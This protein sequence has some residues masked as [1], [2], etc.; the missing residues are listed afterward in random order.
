MVL[1]SV[2]T[3]TE[4]KSSV[5]A[6]GPCLRPADYEEA[7]QV[8]VVAGRRPADRITAGQLGCAGTGGHEPE[9][10]GRDACSHNV[11]TR[12]PS[13]GSWPTLDDIIASLSMVIVIAGAL[14]AVA[15]GRAYRHSGQRLRMISYEP[16]GGQPCMKSLPWS[17]AGRGGRL[18]AR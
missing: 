10:A 11:L 8:H 6:L 5:P 16:P 7:D 4:R 18:S 12:K 13:G 3:D 15:V 17:S 9:P 1:L 14:L 2:H